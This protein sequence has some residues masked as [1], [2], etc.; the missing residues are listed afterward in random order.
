VG[1]PLLLE[2]LQASSASAKVIDPPLLAQL[3]RLLII[4]YIQQRQTL[5]ALDACFPVYGAATVREFAKQFWEVLKIEVCVLFSLAGAS[6]CLM[7]LCE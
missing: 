2:K 4:I 5:E 7:V 3:S 6:L 1:L